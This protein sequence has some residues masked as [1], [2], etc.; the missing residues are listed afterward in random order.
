[1]IA[2]REVPHDL[3]EL[4]HVSVFIL[5]RL[6]LKRRFQFFGICVPEPVSTFTTSLRCSSITCRSPT[7]SAFSLG[8]FT[9]MSL[10]RIWI[11][12]YSRFWP[13]IS[14]TSFFTISPRR[15]A[16]HDLFP[17]LVSTAPP[18]TRTFSPR[19]RRIQRPASDGAQYSRSG[20]KVEMFTGVFGVST[21]RPCSART[22]SSGARAFEPCRDA[23]GAPSLLRRSRSCGPTTCPPARARTRSRAWRALRV[24]ARP[25][26]T[27]LSLPVRPTSPIAARPV[28]TGAFFVAAEATA[29]ATARS[30]PAPR[31]A[32]LPRRSRTR[33]PAPARAR[34]SETARRRSSPAAGGRS[35]VA[36]GGAWRG[37]SGRRAPGSRAGSAACPRA[38]TRL[39]TRSRLLRRGRRAPRGR[40]RPRGPAAVISKMPISF[41]EPKRFFVALSTRCSR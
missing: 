30:A 35:P 17:Q 39:Q 26:S 25:A 32:R 7:R 24:A 29:S 4:E 19:R 8:T 15:G 9:T 16:V 37:R 5:S 1:M 22:T 28:C 12:R 38:C 31:C 41:V 21:E 10:C 11:V 6:Y 33:R 3:G 36:T 2:E 27:G 18:S 14:R 20:R 13:R 34:H 23:P 40:E